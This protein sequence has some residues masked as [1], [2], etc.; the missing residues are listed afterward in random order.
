[1][2]TTAAPAQISESPKSLGARLVGVFFSPGETF[3]DI[4]RKPDFIAPL[5]ILTLASIAVTETMLAKIG[6]ERI[7]RQQIEHSSRASSMSPDQM[8]QAVEQGARIGGII[9]HISGVLAV[10]I[11]LLIIAAVGMLI[12]SAIFG[13]PV[14][15]K[16]AFSVTCYASM[17]SLLGSVMA[18]ALIFF[19][20]PEH[21][22]PQSPMP[23]NPGFF[24]D[25]STSK[26]LLALAGSL[27]IFSFWMMALLGIGFSA[28]SAKK[29]KTTSVFLAFFALW[30]VV[31]LIK[32][33]IAAL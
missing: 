19:G 20:D 31:V 9:A 14:S 18:I 7:V 8:Q 6:I 3:A 2:G 5:V 23:T 25:P 17:V 1:M 13:S 32:V 12:M 11:I 30:A 27:D 15:F 21:F 22:N 28:A 24:L 16:T 33:G 10:P 4:T 29:A 26:P